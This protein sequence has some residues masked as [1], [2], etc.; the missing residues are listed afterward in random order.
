M[1]KFY[2]MRYQHPIVQE[3]N[4]SLEDAFQIASD[5]FCNGSSCCQVIIDEEN[6]VIY[7]LLNNSYLSKD[8][9]YKLQ[10]AYYYVYDCGSFLDTNKIKLIED[11]YR[12]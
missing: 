7:S 12:G 1:F 10:D 9:E 2:R 6:Y 3:L 5:E 11:K 8:F 4:C